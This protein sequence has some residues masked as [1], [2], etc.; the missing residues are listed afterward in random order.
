MPTLNTNFY[1]LLIS[2]GWDGVQSLLM[3][4]THSRRVPQNEFFSFE[5]RN[6]SQGAKSGKYGG[7]AMALVLCLTNQSATVVL[8]CDGAYHSE[9]FIIFLPTNRTFTTNCFS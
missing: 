9:K 7:R 6:K 5:H 2:L 1:I 8:E 4:S 3:A